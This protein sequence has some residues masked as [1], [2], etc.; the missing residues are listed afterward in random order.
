[1]ADF[2]GG[3][4]AKWHDRLTGWVNKWTGL[5]A[6][7]QPWGAHT[8]TGVWRSPTCQLPNS[9]RAPH[10]WPSHHIH[11]IPPFSQGVTLCFQHHWLLPHHGRPQN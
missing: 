11:F 9:Y 1:M 4:M 5:Q 3:E 6:G 8:V 7:Y 10:P 2:I